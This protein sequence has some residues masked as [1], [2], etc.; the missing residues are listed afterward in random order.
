MTAF[1]TIK[2]FNTN[3]GGEAYRA[4]GNGERVNI[5]IQTEAS[6]TWRTVKTMTQADF[7][8]YADDVGL[9]SP[10]CNDP[11]LLA[12]LANPDF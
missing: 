10:Y 4:T 11:S 8:R 12:E 9:D 1:R 7:D 3:F 2:S 5:Q 6:N